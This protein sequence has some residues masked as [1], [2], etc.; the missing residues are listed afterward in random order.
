MHLP[1]VERVIVVN[2]ISF[3]TFK[4]FINVWAKIKQVISCGLRGN[5]QLGPYSIGTVFMPK[6]GLTS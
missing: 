2:S 5:T 1:L 6:E 4:C 3:S